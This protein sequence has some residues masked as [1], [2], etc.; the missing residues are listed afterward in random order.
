MDM[1]FDKSNADERKTWLCNYDRDDIME[2]EH[3]SVS[4]SDFF[5]RRMIHFS[6]YDCERSIPNIVDG[7]KTSQRKIV[8][9]ALKRS[10]YSEIQ[11]AQFAGYVSEHSGYHHGEN[12][13]NQAIVSMAQTY[14][15]SNNINIFLELYKLY[16]SSETYPSGKVQPKNGAVNLALA[17]V[18]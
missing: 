16:F 15:G 9:S 11:V 12:S 14:V 1:V 18:P 10:L 13:L 8:F 6:K 3:D 17:V 4:Y 2:V 7:L 5:N